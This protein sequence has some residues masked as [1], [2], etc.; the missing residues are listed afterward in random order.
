MTETA[1]TLDGDKFAK[2][3]VLFADGIE[4]SDTGT[5]D[6]CVFDGINVRGNT[7][8]C[9]GAKK[10]VLGISTITSNTI[11]RLILTHLELPALA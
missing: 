3:D 7:N 5:Q 1:E 8:H 4:D 9:F 10:H 6:G 11:Y 2:G